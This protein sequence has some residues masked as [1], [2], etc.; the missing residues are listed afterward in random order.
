[1]V[2]GECGTHGT[3]QKSVQDFWCERSKERDHSEDRGV[4][5]RMGSE[6]ILQLGRLAVDV[7]GGFGWFRAGAGGGLLLTR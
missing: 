6:W 7:W 2:G 1:V 4:D 3:G 5:G